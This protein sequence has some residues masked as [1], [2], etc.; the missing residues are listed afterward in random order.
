MRKLKRE[1]N[2]SQALVR[3]NSEEFPCAFF[4]H[5]G[6]SNCKAG[7]QTGEQNGFFKTRI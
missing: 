7:E 4:S 5:F 1:Q 3:S 2:K 6:G